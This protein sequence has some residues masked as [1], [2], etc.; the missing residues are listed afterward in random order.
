MCL[1]LAV[2]VKH[3]VYS[4]KIN[5]TFEKYEP[6]NDVVVY[7]ADQNNTHW[8]GEVASMAVALA[9]SAEED[10]SMAVAAALDVA[11]I[12]PSAP[13]VATSIRYMTQ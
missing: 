3:P 9:A 11:A 12:L 7:A 1:I 13:P 8:H 6:N 2:A 4:E 10:S 5:I